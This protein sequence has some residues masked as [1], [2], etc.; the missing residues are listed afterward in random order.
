M[1]RNDRVHEMTL[2]ENPTR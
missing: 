1:P 2:I